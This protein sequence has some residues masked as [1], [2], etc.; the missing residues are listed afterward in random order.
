MAPTYLLPTGEF[1]TLP[2]HVHNVRVSVRVVPYLLPQPP[3]VGTE[4]LACL[5]HLPLTA[6]QLPHQFTDGD[7]PAGD[8][9]I[10]ASRVAFCNK[11]VDMP[12]LQP[13]IGQCRG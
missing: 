1:V 12:F 7:D 4:R 2:P 6:M 8:P 11:R 9:S 10:V 13:V 3:Q 5:P